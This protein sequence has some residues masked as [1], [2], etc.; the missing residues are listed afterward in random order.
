MGTVYFY[1][2]DVKGF[3][4]AY[5]EAYLSLLGLET[6]HVLSLMVSPSLLA[7]LSAYSSTATRRGV[8]LRPE[9]KQLASRGPAILGLIYLYAPHHYAEDGAS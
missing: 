9:A 8:F 5:D 1:K 3:V 4:N 7:D 6:P 2:Q